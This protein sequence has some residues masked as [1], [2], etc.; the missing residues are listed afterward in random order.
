MT[1]RRGRGDEEFAITR[2]LGG[3][4]SALCPVVLQ[5]ASSHPG[6]QKMEY[7]A[8]V[9]TTPTNK[10]MEYIRQR[11]H[12]DDDGYNCLLQVPYRLLPP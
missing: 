2:S 10:K 9:E 7:R 1:V 12:F 11:T 8:A 4:Q 6:Q 3:T 5:K